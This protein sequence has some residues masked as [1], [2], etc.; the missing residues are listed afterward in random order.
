[1][2]TVMKNTWNMVYGALDPVTVFWPI[3][4]KFL[5]FYLVYASIYRVFVYAVIGI[6]RPPYWTVFSFRMPVLP[7]AAWP[8]TGWLFLWAISIVCQIWGYIMAKSTNVK[9][10]LAGK[11]LFWGAF[12]WF[13]ALSF[14]RW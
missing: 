13:L 2:V 10:T 4:E 14:S 8:W 6:E 12:I 7:G 1:M 3:I 11:A 5:Y 9:T